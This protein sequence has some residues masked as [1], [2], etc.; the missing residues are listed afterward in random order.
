MNTN[1]VTVEIATRIQ[2]EVSDRCGA[3]YDDMETIAEK[4]AEQGFDREEIDQTI[5]D[6]L[7]ELSKVYGN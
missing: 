4:Y 3:G 7:A 2:S 1:T 6:A 5:A